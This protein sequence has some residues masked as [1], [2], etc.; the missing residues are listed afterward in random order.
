MYNSLILLSKTMDWED[1]VVIR[2]MSDPRMIVFSESTMSLLAMLSTTQ[3]QTQT[4]TH[5]H[6]C[7]CVKGCADYLM[8]YLNF[9]RHEKK[10]VYE[11]VNT[12][13]LLPVLNPYPV[14]LAQE[15]YSQKYV[16]K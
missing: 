14:S 7:G 8:I 10:K 2:A 16:R 11:Y 13:F 9:S 12:S 4:Q 5:T 6:T 3:T 15:T 1:F